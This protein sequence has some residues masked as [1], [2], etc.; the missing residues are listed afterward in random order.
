MTTITDW[1]AV[2]DDAVAS[3]KA[4]CGHQLPRRDNALVWLRTE[5]VGSNVEV[6]SLCYDCHD[7]DKDYSITLD[8]AERLPQPRPSR[9]KVEYL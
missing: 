2:V 1:R 6:Y 3:R 8:Y 9:V 4:A 5:K 7:R